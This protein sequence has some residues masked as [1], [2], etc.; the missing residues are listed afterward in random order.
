MMHDFNTVGK[1]STLQN[2]DIS[3]MVIIRY[4]A[5]VKLINYANLLLIYQIES[6][7]SVPIT[8]IFVPRVGNNYQETI[9]PN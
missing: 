6:Q 1:K 9:H 8:Y 3:V 7:T 2:K 5:N 4:I